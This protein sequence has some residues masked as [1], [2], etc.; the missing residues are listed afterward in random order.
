MSNTY[1]GIKALGLIGIAGL[2]NASA[3]AQDAQQISPEDAKK[4]FAASCS[5]CHG[6][7]GMKAGKGG[8]KLAGTTKDEEGV[9][10][11]ILKGQGA[12]PTFKNTLT[13]VQA[14]ALAKYIK[15]LPSE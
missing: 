9:Y 12:M 15:S 7:F 13:E 6:S 10:N 4:L 5:W 8:P 1:R 2:L 11:T 3:M 14:R